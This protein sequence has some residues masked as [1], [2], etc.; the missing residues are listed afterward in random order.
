MRIISYAWARI[1]KC[2]LNAQ[3]SSV[4]VDVCMFC[5]QSFV[6]LY[7]CSFAVCLKILHQ[8]HEIALFSMACVWVWAK[9]YLW[10]LFSC[11]PSRCNLY[12]SRSL[13]SSFK[14]R[15]VL[16]SIASLF[17]CLFFFYSVSVCP[18]NHAR[19]W[20]YHHHHHHRVE[21]S[22]IVRSQLVSFYWIFIPSFTVYLFVYVC[23]VCN[24]SDIAL[25]TQKVCLPWYEYE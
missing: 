2:V 7:V 18:D 23:N 8:K 24:A 10:N 1:V 14:S 15:V 3:S 22:A 19:H 12:L 11:S 20:H 4:C 16:L 17:L 13:S 6:C 5:L 21:C 9:N 25:H